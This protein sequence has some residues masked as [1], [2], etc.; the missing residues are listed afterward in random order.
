MVRL[1]NSSMVIESDWKFEKWV[2]RV[3]RYNFGILERWRSLT[4]SFHVVFISAC[5][6]MYELAGKSTISKNLSKNVRITKNTENNN[7]ELLFFCYFFIY[8][9]KMHQC[10]FSRLTCFGVNCVNQLIYKSLTKSTLKTFFI[11]F[12]EHSY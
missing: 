2:Y 4:R 7:L 6:R 9:L 12:F 3:A 1:K 5:T 8:L 10:N 11:A